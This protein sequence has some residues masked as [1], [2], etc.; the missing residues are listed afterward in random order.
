MRSFLQRMAIGFFTG[1]VASLAAW[2]LAWLL[3]RAGVGPE[4]APPLVDHLLSRMAVGALWGLGMTLF[5][6]LAW[7]RVLL[8][9]LVLSL[10]PAALTWWQGGDW[11]L[12]RGP[13]APAWILGAWAFWGLTLGFLG[14]WL[15]AEPPR[16]PAGRSKK[17]RR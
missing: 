6:G 4:Q 3:G 2:G 16:S 12:A 17:K 15:G 11:P 1:G 9:G 14:A 10:A 5:L 7:S 8:A 13:W